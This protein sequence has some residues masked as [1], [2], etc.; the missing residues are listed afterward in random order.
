LFVPVI[1]ATTT[2]RP[3]GYFRLEWSLAEQRS[4]VIGRNKAFIVPVCLDQTAQPGAVVPEAFQRMQW[5]R[6]PG[7]HATAAFVE[8]VGRLLAPELVG[9][10]TSASA[11][12]VVSAPVNQ[13]AAGVHRQSRSILILIVALITIVIAYYLVHEYFLRHASP[14][15]AYPPAKAV[16]DNAMHTSVTPATFATAHF[17][18]Y[19]HSIAVLPLANMSGDKRQDYFSDSL[20][21]EPLTSLSRMHELQVA[22]RTSA[23][24][25]KGKDIDIGAIARKLNRA[26]ILECTVRRSAHTV[27]ITAQLINAGMGY[28]LSELGPAHAHRRPSAVLSLLMSPGYFASHQESACT[29]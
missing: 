20:T 25:F 5:T 16:G 21:E 28:P 22:P 26:D 17:H 2:A 11:A 3:E 8:R 29:V 23:F 7:G 14:A 15:P 12:T 1:S 4:H 13:A 6:L 19:P 24:S 18:P 10:P 9:S 27:R